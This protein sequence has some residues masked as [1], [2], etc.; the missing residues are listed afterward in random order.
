MPTPFLSTMY[1]LSSIN[2][3]IPSSTWPEI[4]HTRVI[5]H[6]IRIA[7]QYYSRIHGRRLAQLLNLTAEELELEIA[8]MVSEGSVCAKIDRPQDIVRFKAF[9]TPEEI[10]SEW[11]SDI[12]SLLH[13]DDSTTHLIH[14]E[15]MTQ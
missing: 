13:L 14:K 2:E 4:F 5:Q 1:S 11:G 15:N 6:N 10:L 12:K 3:Q 9:K 7:A 8:S